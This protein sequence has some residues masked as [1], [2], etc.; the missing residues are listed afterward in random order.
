MDSPPPMP[1][2]TTERTL[3][4]LAVLVGLA[5][6]YIFMI[7]IIWNRVIVEKFPKADIQKMTFW[8]SLAL[9][10]FFSLLSGGAGF[11]RF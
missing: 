10:V 4:S 1:F 5:V 7:Q 3:V 11:V 8:D 9:A 2:G 6:L